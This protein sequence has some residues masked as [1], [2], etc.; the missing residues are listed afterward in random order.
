MNIDTIIQRFAGLSK[1]QQAIA[2]AGL[3]HD[4]TIMARGTYSVGEGTVDVTDSARVTA[5]KI[6]EL[7]HCVTAAIGERLLSAPGYP[8][9][10]LV[11]IA[12]DPQWN[13]VAQ[14]CGPWFV[15]TLAE[16]GV[17]TGEDE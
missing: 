16:V 4:L 5:H 14:S 3:A 8:D 6:N 15:R 12:M 9:D 2:L 13:P 17:K 7:L 10:V 11:R 1:E